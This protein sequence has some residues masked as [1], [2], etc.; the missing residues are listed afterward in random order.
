MKT[1][2]EIMTPS[3]LVTVGPG[4]TVAEAAKAIAENGVSH[5]LVTRDS[6]LVGVVC[7]CDL[8]TAAGTMCVSDLMHAEPVTAEPAMST[9][10]ALARMQAHRVSCMPVMAGADLAGV[11][12]LSDLRHAGLGG[13]VDAHCAACGSD[14]HVRTHEHMQVVGFCIDCRRSSAPPRWDDDLGGG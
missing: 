4:A 10:D 1:V 7:I 11:I 6:A 2:S 12:T 14:D 3:P 5:L 13:D 9:Q 8:D